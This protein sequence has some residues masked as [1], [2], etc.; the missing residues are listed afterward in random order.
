MTITFIGVFIFVLGSIIALRGSLRQAF[1]FLFITALFSGSAAVILPGGGSSIPPDFFALAF[2]YLRI[3]APSGGFVG[4]VPDAIRDHRWLALF[5]LYG[6]AMAFIGPRLFAGDISVY[7]MRM[8]TRDSLFDTLPLEPTQQNITGAVYLIGT[9]LIAMAAW[10][11]SR[12]SDGPQTLV[13][14]VVAVAWG[15]IA[16]GLIGIVARGT[17]LDTVLDLFRNSTYLQLDDAIGGL[18]RVRGIFPEA[19][20]YAGFGFAYFVANAE[21]WYRSIRSRA[22]GAAALAMGAILFFSTSSTAYIALGLYV[23]FFIARVA[24]FPNI[25]EGSK[26]KSLFVVLGA[27]GVVV[28]SVM[29]TVPDI[30]ES[31]FDMVLSMTVEKP[32]SDSGAQRLFWAMQGRDAFLVSYGLGI[33]PGSFRS[34]SMIMAIVGSMGLAGIIF[35]LFHLLAV[36]QPW[37]KSTWGPADDYRTAVGGAFASAA[38]LCLIPP[39][40]N[41]ANAHPTNPFAVFAGAALALRSSQLLKRGSQ[42]ADGAYGSGHASKWEETKRGG[43]GLPAR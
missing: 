29:A 37:R 12:R 3:L 30:V 22:T 39:A 15:H 42:S 5:V 35:F 43:P 2:I 27:F 19:S 11:A 34:S 18:I 17:P 6:V 28:A 23:V 21:L 14:A 41:S 8:M 13:T 40:I 16:F 20:Q 32:S 10:I 4:A 31:I 26:V 25:A 24:L 36:F 33:G 38:L 7:P 9:L 1:L